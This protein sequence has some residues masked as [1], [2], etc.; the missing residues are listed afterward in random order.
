MHFKRIYRTS[1]AMIILFGLVLGMPQFN[2]ATAACANIITIQY[3]AGCESV[4]LPE[5]L[6]CIECSSY[7]GCLGPEGQPPANYDGYCYAVSCACPDGD[8]IGY[9]QSCDEVVSQTCGNAVCET[10]EN[11]SSCS[12]D[13]GSCAE[14]SCGDSFC[15]GF[16]SCLTCTQDCGICEVENGSWWQVRGG[17]VGS[18]AESGLAIESNIPITSCQLPDCDPSLMST[19]TS[20]LAN[21]AG[22]VLT[23]G[24]S[25]KVNGGVTSG[26]ENIFSV[27]TGQSRYYEYFD[28]FFRN[29]D[30]GLLPIDDFLTTYTEAQKPNYSPTKIEYY[31]NGDLTIRSQWHVVSGEQYVIFVDGDLF[32]TDGDGSSDQLIQ[33]DNG[34]FL[35]FIVSGNIYI[36]ES[37]GNSDLNN[38]TANIEGVFIANGMIQVQSRGISGGGDD[39]FIAE[40]TFVGWSGVQLERDFDDGFNRDEEN[41]DTPTEQFIYRPDFVLHLPQVLRI[42]PRIWQQTQ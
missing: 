11:C 22:Y 8:I 42:S 9:L 15:T 41:S 18:N 40:G 32:M 30:F 35:S 7:Q 6:N 4:C 28:F 19:D 13:C 29:T 21:S 31:R 38:T 12:Q 34:G 25:L 26:A 16:E 17:L 24:G 10:N 1:C 14:Q 27:G 3:P 5:D 23:M 36:D 37:L 39:R 2:Q 33:V 20:G